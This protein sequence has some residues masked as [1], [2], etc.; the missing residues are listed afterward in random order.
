MQVGVVVTGGRVQGLAWLLCVAVVAVSFRR[1]TVIM[2]I[3]SMIAAG[4][5]GCVYALGRKAFRPAT[6]SSKEAT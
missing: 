6:T 5:M 3:V 1:H 2:M 4:L